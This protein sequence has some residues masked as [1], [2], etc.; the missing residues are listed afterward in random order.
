MKASEFKKL[1][2]EA[3]KEAIREE[4]LETAQQ[5]LTQPAESTQPA[6]VYEK[7]GNAMLD[8][9]NETRTSMT[10]EDYRSMTG[11]TLR[12]SLAQ[13]YDRSM[14]MPKQ[15]FAPVSKDP[16]AVAQS[17]AAAPKIGLDISQLGF[18]NKAAAIVDEAGRKDK[19]RFGG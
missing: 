4:L 3:V 14:F 19:A 13:N 18:V 2:K 17:M 6:V 10:S 9:L 11:T 5:P 8:A 12:S 16:R 15:S 7:T 1:I